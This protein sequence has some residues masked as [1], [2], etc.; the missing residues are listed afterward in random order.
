MKC[1]CQ[2]QTARRLV[3]EEETK[4]VTDPLMVVYTAWPQ[5][6]LQN[7]TVKNRVRTNGSVGI[8]TERTQGRGT[9]HGERNR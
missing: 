3:Q 4:R 7:S 5:F 8:F 2:S 1:T 9:S 6:S